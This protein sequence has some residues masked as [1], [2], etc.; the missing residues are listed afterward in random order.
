MTRT[1]DALTVSC[2]F[3]SKEPPTKAP[4][5]LINSIRSLLDVRVAEVFAIVRNVEKWLGMQQRCNYMRSHII[6]LDIHTFSV[7]Q[8]AILT[9][10]VQQNPR[11]NHGFKMLLRPKP[12]TSLY[13][14]RK[15]CHNLH[16]HL[17]PG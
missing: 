12:K 1:K 2:L 5:Y 13:L 11:R 15:S 10:Q 9:F 7:L 8:V 3:S 6:N 17:C 4:F 16:G 14:Q